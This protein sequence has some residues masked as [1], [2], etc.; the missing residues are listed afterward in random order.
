MRKKTDANL[1]TK[2]RTSELPM[3]AMYAGMFL[4]AAISSELLKAK[5]LAAKQ[6]P[7]ADALFNGY[8]ALHGRAND[9]A[10]SAKE[11]GQLLFAWA[12]T[13]ALDGGAA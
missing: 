10:R 6:S 8:W 2:L 5:W 11:N 3:Q 7:M 4:E 13:T 9:M 12:G 1:L